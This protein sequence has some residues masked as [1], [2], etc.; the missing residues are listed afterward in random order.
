MNDCVIEEFVGTC[1]S[2]GGNVTGYKTPDDFFTFMCD[3]TKCNNHVGE[4]TSG[5]YPE[6]V[7]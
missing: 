2:C 5:E 1:I 6:W 3:N 4:D 7:E